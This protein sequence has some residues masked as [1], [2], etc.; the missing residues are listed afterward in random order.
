MKISEKMQDMLCEQI[1]QELN[2]GYL[3]LSMAA[4]LEDRSLP[5]FASW[6]KI[7]AEEEKEHAMKLFDFVHERGGRVSLKGLNAP[8]YEWADVEEVF[9]DAYAHE[10]KVT[11]LIYLL[12]DA[13]NSER[14]Y[15]TARMLDWFVHEQVEE[16][17]SASSILDK[18]R[19]AK[20]SN[21]ALLYID[22][23]LGKRKAH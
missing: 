12:V 22:K 7:Q 10:Q 13:A 11:D 6:M 5:G 20:G 18:I 4:F 14:D 16:E 8:K 9:V 15:A 3:Y 21:G 2:A 17:D 19:M 23:E 1:N